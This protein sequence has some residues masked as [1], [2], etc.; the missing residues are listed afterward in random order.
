MVGAVQTICRHFYHGTFH[1]WVC[2]RAWCLCWNKSCCKWMLEWF[3][4]HFLW[5]AILDQMLW[6]VPGIHCSCWSDWRLWPCLVL[7][8]SWP[9]HIQYSYE[10]QSM[11]YKHLFQVWPPQSISLT[12]FFFPL[13]SNTLVG[14]C[15][16]RERRMTRTSV[17]SEIT[18]TFW[19]LVAACLARII[20]LVSPSSYIDLNLTIPVTSSFHDLKQRS[21]SVTI[22]ITLPSF[23][24]L[25]S[26]FQFSARNTMSL[27]L[28]SVL[29]SSWFDVLALSDFFFYINRKQA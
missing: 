27:A 1:I 5:R 28:L 15:E 2:S 18:T 21:P 17:S 8:R 22:S 25:C 23:S 16:Q 24:L 6:T 20:I 26:S 19:Q 12:A 14:I 7:Q 11:Q 3:E 4:K 13:L 10:H 29:A 9:S